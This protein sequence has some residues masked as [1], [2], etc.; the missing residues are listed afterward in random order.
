ME[1]FVVDSIKVGHYKRMLSERRGVSTV[2]EENF[3]YLSGI[4]RESVGCKVCRKVEIN[5]R[6]TNEEFYG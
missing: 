4:W 6:L 1:D 3:P 2:I 5:R